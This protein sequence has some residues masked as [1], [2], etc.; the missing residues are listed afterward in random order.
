MR[1]GQHLLYFTEHSVEG[2]FDIAVHPALASGCG[3]AADRTVLM[4]KDCTQLLNA[5]NVSARVEDRRCG[6]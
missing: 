2:D 1:C 5:P 4:T 3:L 6:E